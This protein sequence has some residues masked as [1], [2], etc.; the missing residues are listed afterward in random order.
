MRLFFP[1]L[2]LFGCASGGNQ[3]IAKSGP[4][5][6]DSS[7]SKETTKTSET[8]QINELTI[9]DLDEWTDRYADGKEGDVR[10]F[11]LTKVMSTYALNRLQA[12]EVQNTYRDLT[13]ANNSLIGDVGL[14]RAI[15]QVRQGELESGVDAERLAQ[16][17]FIVVFDL[18]D[19]LYD[20]YYDGGEACHTVKYVQPNGSTKYIQATPG[21]DTVIKQIRR[22]GGEVAIFSANLDDRT[23]RNLKHMSL[24]GIPLTQSEHIAGIMTNSHLIRQEKT[25]PPGSEAKPRKGRPVLEPSKDLRPFDEN[26]ERVIIVD[27]NPLRLFQYGNTRLI[28]KF[29]ADEYCRTQ[30]LELKSAYENL[31][32][33]V[34]REIEESVKYMQA[35]DGTSFVAAYRPYTYLGGVSLQFLMDTRG[36]SR[37]D[38][39]DYLRR[40]PDIVDSRF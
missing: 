28:K 3:V 11:N 18:D 29:H 9:P 4:E 14:A 31:L 21:W 16:A 23:I 19:T 17:A 22:L 2:V 10:F 7:H 36:W 12:L 32:V 27:D 5:T 24:D 37:A 15:D 13:R 39:I 25:E 26:L 40:N 30:N 34:G 38:A 33:T 8:R 20:Q 1:L 6:P 35:N